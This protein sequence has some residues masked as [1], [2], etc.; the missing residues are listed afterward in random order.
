MAEEREASAWLEWPDGVAHALRERPVLLG[1]GAENDVV[2]ADRQASQLHAVVLTGSRGLELWALGRNPTLRNGGVVTGR[3]ALHDGDLLELPGALLRVRAPGRALRGSWCLA[4]AGGRQVA[5]RALPYSVGGGPGDD[6]LLPGWPPAALRLHGAQG[7]LSMELG[8]PAALN[9]APQ[10]EGAIERVEHGDV[11][12]LNGIEARLLALEDGADTPT[13]LAEETPLPRAVHFQF[14]PTGGTLTV[15]FR[16]G[17]AVQV[18]LSELRARLVA[19]LLAPPAP[20]RAGDFVSDEALL[21]AIWP[22]EHGRDR[23]DLNVLVHRTRKDLLSA[24][25][26][27]VQL[28]ARA[29]RGGATAL[30]LAPGCAVEVR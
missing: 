19:T 6:L 24:G 26:D 30:C 18:P 3:V 2:L 5:L 11:L 20:Y 22:G 29:A 13:W 28:L 27:P 4:L 9:G 12:M 15:R 10:P 23:T 8:A 7:A 25:L 1:R 16:E 17:P 21:P 14:M